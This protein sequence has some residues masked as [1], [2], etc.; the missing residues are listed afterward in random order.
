MTKH[1]MIRTAVAGAVALLVGTEPLRAQAGPPLARPARDTTPAL[2][3]PIAPSAPPS[4][5]APRTGT[6]AAARASV[7]SAE[8]QIVPPSTAPVSPPVDSFRPAAART[9]AA[10]P[11]PVV[12]PPPPPK[13]GTEARAVSASA[14]LR[15]DEPPPGA[16][17][18]CRDGTFL[19]GAL[20]ADPCGDR[21]GLAVRITPPPPLRPPRPD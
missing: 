4:S 19:S 15:S 8:Q 20:P 5:V 11:I 10:P 3:S 12:A 17:A 16:T 6:R 13:P 2:K 1:F 7:L 21:G 14:S 18:R 9:P